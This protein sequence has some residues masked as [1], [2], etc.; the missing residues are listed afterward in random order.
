MSLLALPL[1]PM[2]ASA[3]LTLPDTFSSTSC[4]RAKY[5]FTMASDTIVAT[6][7][8]AHWAAMPIHGDTMAATAAPTAKQRST[9]PPLINS[10]I[11]HTTAATAHLIHAFSAIHSIY[12]QCNN[13]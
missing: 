4:R 7:N 11:T 8:T 9:S 1:R 5:F 6:T 3:L 10:K 12:L 13:D 2:R